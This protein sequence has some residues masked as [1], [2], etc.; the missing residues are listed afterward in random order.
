MKDAQILGSDIQFN[1]N[2]NNNH[3]LSTK[4]GQS[5]VMVMVLYHGGKV[6]LPFNL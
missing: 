5:N 3:E 6:Y 2:N 4:L 1:N